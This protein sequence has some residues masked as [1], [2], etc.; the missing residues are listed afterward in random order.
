MDSQAFKQSL[1]GRMVKATGGH[2]AFVPNPLPPEIEW[3]P[4]LV[5]ALSEADRAVGYLGGLGQILPNPYL[6][7]RPLQRQEAVLSS[8]IEGTQASLSDLYAYEGTRVS[9]QELA[10]DVQE[11]HNY[12]Q[13]LEC[14]LQQVRAGIPVTLRLVRELHAILMRSVRGTWHRPGQF[15]TTQNWIGPAGCTLEQATFVPPPPEHLDA[16]LNE[17]ER[18]LHAPSQLPPLVRLALSHYQ[19]EATH[20]LS[21]IHISEPT[22]PY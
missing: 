13:A 20:P 4:Q 2:G 19:F 14:G 17:W 3:T 18:F 10:N 9:H 5:N 1:S 22:R 12:V 8:R 11:V 7:V 6:L 15:R 16:A 21:L